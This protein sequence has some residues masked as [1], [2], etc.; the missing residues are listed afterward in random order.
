[1][2]EKSMTC[3][4][5]G[6]ITRQNAKGR[7]FSLAEFGKVKLLKDVEVPLCKKCGEAVIE[8]EDY[9][10][11]NG[12]EASLPGNVEELLS[13]IKRRHKIINKDV[14]VFLGMKPE[15]L[16]RYQSETSGQTIPSPAFLELKN[17]VQRGRDYMEKLLEYEWDGE[18]SAETSGSGGGADHQMPTSIVAAPYR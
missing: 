4:C 7:F 10:L 6:R 13:L 2:V 17:M 5:G 1:M 3:E 9:S 14:A 11:D 15:T 12:L 16:S 8:M 18:A